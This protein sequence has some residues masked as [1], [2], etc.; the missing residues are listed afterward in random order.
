MAA[1]IWLIE[2]MTRGKP[3]V[4]ICHE[5][6]IMDCK[7]LEIQHWS[8]RPT[9]SA[10]LGT[11]RMYRIIVMT[12]KTA[13]KGNAAVQHNDHGHGRTPSSIDEGRISIWDAVASGGRR[14]SECGRAYNKNIEKRHQGG[15]TNTKTHQTASSSTQ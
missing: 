6:L 10:N 1:H 9:C 7:C 2:S 5:E 12:G 14:M 11:H 13:I 3:L 15:H 4:G 8:I